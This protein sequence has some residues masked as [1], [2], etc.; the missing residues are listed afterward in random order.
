MIVSGSK[1][2]LI[3]LS[4]RWCKSSKPCK[5]S[6]QR[7]AGGVH[8]AWKPWNLGTGVSKNHGFCLLAYQK[9]V[10]NVVPKRSVC[11]KNPSSLFGR[12]WKL[13]SSWYVWKYIFNWMCFT[14]V[15]NSPREK[16]FLCRAWLW[17]TEPVRPQ[18]NCIACGRSKPGDK[19]HC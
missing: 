17:L 11:C 10:K 4:S 13:F 6:N 12:V 7:N 1:K 18:W 19:H 9:L 14:F 8:T 15:T 5:R 2:D 3:A 16:R